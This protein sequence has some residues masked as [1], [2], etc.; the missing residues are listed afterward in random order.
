MKKG[1][2]TIN[3]IK[4]TKGNE[5][6]IWYHGHQEKYN[7]H[8]VLGKDKFTQKFVPAD[9]R[10]FFLPVVPDRLFPST[11]CSGRLFRPVVP[12]MDVLFLKEKWNNKS[13]QQ[14]EIGTTSRNNRLK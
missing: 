7:I 8:K 14:V 6:Q 3:I 1:I 5:Q 13:E 4:S 11:G 2:I 10:L 9:G 12:K